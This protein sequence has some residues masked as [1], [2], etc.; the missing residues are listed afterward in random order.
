MLDIERDLVT[1]AQHGFAYALAVDQHVGCGLAQHRLAV[2]GFDQCVLGGDALAFDADV[3]IAGAADPAWRLQAQA[4]AMMAAAH[5]AQGQ[6]QVGDRILLALTGGWRAVAIGAQQE[7]LAAVHVDAVAG[8]QHRHLV[9]R[10]AI[11]VHAAQAFRHRHPDAAAVVAQAQKPVAV[12][13]GGAEPGR[14]AAQRMHAAADQQVGL[15]PVA[16]S[17]AQFIHRAAI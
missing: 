13:L 5:P 12:L 1:V 3:G 11:H 14:Q 16:E 2:A 7:Q 10:A 9:D 6:A 4:A 8:A 17:Q 15:V